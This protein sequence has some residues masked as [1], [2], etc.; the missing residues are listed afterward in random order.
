MLDMLDTVYHV[1]MG[2]ITEILSSMGYLILFL[3]AVFLVE[4]PVLILSVFGM[5]RWSTIAKIEPELSTTPKVSCVV[6]A[7]SEGEDV[8]QSIVS[9]CEQTYKGVIEIIVLVDGCSQ[10]MHTYRAALEGKTYADDFDNRE[11]VVIPKWKRG[12]L[13]SSSNAGLSFATGDIIIRTDA[14]TSFN[15][16]MVVHMVHEFEDPNVPA[17]AGALYARNWR[18]SII[19]NFQGLEYITSINAAKTGL[20]QWGVITNISGAFGAFRRD[21]LRKIGG[22]NTDTSE[23]LDLTLRI[24]QYFKRYPNLR[25]SFTPKAIAYT[26]VPDRVTNLIKQRIRWDG[27]LLYIYMYKHKHSLIWNIYSPKIYLTVMLLGILQQVVIPFV[28][29]FFVSWLF[30]EYSLGFALLIM[31]IQYLYYAFSI[32]FVFACYMLMVSRD[33]KEDLKM[34]SM[35]VFMP[36]YTLFLRFVTCFAIVNQVWRRGHEETTMS[37]WWVIRSKRRS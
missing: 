14:D 31:F 34:C 5:W 13:V 8:I 1:V 26:D 15:N 36:L 4:L 27:D 11:V 35:L 2:H 30:Y 16:T 19:A 32:T 3:P 25:I 20:A 7:Y 17:V 18:N 24:Q 10:N 29:V 28:I 33:P 37:P 6:A 9:L 23:D 12:G 22:W 21:F